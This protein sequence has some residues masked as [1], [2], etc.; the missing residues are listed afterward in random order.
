ML[1]HNHR[2]AH[3]TK[4]AQRLNEKVVVALVQSDARLVEDV[5]HIHQLRADLCGQADTLSLTTGKRGR[6]TIQ[7]QILHTYIA[8]ELQSEGDFAQ[9]LAGYM[10]FGGIQM[11]RQGLA[12]GKQFRHIHSSEVGDAFV[13][14]A[15]VQRLC[16]QPGTVA[17]RTR[18]GVHELGNPFL[19]RRRHILFTEVADEIHNPLKRFLHGRKSCDLPFHMQDLCGAIQHRIQL[20]LVQ[21]PDRI[22][23]GKAILLRKGLQRSEQQCVLVF[24]KNSDATSFDRLVFVRNHLVDVYFRD[25]A[26][27]VA[28]FTRTVWRVERKRVGFRLRIRDARSGTHQ[29]LAVI[30]HLFGLIVKDHNGALAIF[31]RNLHA[32]G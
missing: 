11:D 4:T 7:R 20:L 21:I 6:R 23:Q 29:E 19:E 3:V 9:N 27:S 26:Q 13:L 10:S 5:H 17:M 31:H 1:H 25:A 18:D 14:Y 12:P 22:G 24:S 8:Q 32:V 16:A 15:E 2:V 30:L 28:I